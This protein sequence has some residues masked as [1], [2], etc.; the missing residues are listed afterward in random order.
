MILTYYLTNAGAIG[1]VFADF[2]IKVLPDAV[3]W[4]GRDDIGFSAMYN[5]L[6]SNLML[7]LGVLS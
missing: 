7:T 1:R 5:L 3:E 2:D 4:I 6:R